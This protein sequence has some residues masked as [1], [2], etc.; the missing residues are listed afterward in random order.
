MIYECTQEQM[1]C[2]IYECTQEQ[3]WC[4]IYE[5]TQEQM[6]C[7]IYECTQEQMWCVIYECTQEQ[8]WCV[9]YECTQEQMWCYDIWV[10]SRADVM[11]YI[12]VLTRRSDIHWSSGSVGSGIT[13]QPHSDIH[14]RVKLCDVHDILG[15]MDGMGLVA[16]DNCRV[17]SDNC[18]AGGRHRAV[19]TA[20]HDVAVWSDELYMSLNLAFD[21][22]AAQQE[23]HTLISMTCLRRQNQFHRPC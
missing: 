8:M 15:S 22:L 3:M 18:R 5:C 10:Y 19:V 4:V 14:T 1:W 6:W 20:H 9:I 17:A 13:A 12:W 7:V 11:C 2:V 16:S 21:N 23:W